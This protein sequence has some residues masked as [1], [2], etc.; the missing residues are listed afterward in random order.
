M[1]RLKSPARPPVESTR[2]L[3]VVR[4]H[5]AAVSCRSVPNVQENVDCSSVEEF[6]PELSPRRYFSSG[7]RTV[8]SGMERW[9]F[10]GQA[11]AAWPL[12]PAALRTHPP[13]RLYTKA[14]WHLNS[15]DT[16]GAQLHAEYFTAQR[17]FW[18]ADAQGIALPGDS[19]SV[20]TA[21]AR[22]QHFSSGKETGPGLFEMVW[23][24][25]QLIDILALAQHAGLPTRL[26]DW[27]RRPL[28]AAYFAAADAAR[29]V[30]AGRLLDQDLLVVWAFRTSVLD[31]DLW[32]NWY[33]EGEPSIRII[34]PPR[35]GNI[36]LHA[37]AGVFTFQRWPLG[38]P[39]TPVKREPLDESMRR[40]RLPVDN[41]ALRRITLPV[42]LAPALLTRLYEEE[43]TAASVFPGI[44]GVVQ[45]LEEERFL[46]K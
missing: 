44:R 27:T 7:Q 12:L 41:T 8:E 22:L 6:L 4:C 14:G 21:L 10:R 24:P 18:A 26:L 17:F 19:P 23:P 29:G 28:I 20:R 43:V 13:P 45:Q 16:Q 3:I 32:N 1:C 46:E 2:V 36:N 25:D 42:R 39:T 35:A 31:N 30:A 37:Q 33:E 11:N 5:G 40:T 15:S 34:A 9:I 38:N